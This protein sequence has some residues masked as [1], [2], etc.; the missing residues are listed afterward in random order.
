MTTKEAIE[1]L[2]D[3]NTWRRGYYAVGDA[4]ILRRDQRR[5]KITAVDTFNY[6]HPYTLENGQCISYKDIEMP[7][8]F[9]AGEAI[10]YA[11]DYMNNKTR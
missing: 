6:R 5:H 10:D 3:F 11:I 7:D 1:I 2:R 8:P 4:V 9:T